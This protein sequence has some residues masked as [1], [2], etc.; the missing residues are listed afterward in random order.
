MKNKVINPE[1]VEFIPDSLESGILYISM[2]YSVAVHLCA[3]GCGKE[4]VTLFSPKDW[5]LY[6]DGDSVSL[7]PS[8]G[9][10]E[11]PCKSHYFIKYNQI[12]WCAAEPYK[13]MN[14]KR[15]RIL[16]LKSGLIIYCSA[17]MYPY[18]FEYRNMG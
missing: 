7:S 6:F 18:S 9:N 17:L 13:K 1:F 8:I 16:K 11:Y 15:T 10:Y 3:C 2:K 12:D 4:V 14:K 5:K